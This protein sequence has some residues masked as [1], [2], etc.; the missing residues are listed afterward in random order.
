MRVGTFFRESKIVMRM[1]EIEWNYQ[2]NSVRVGMTWHGQGELVLM[3]PALSSISTRMEMWPLQERLGSFFTTLAMDWVGFGDRPRP[4]LRWS[5]EIYRS[6]LAYLLDEVVPWPFA[7]IA[8]GH[9]AAY[10]L[11][12]AAARPGSTGRLCLI[13]PTWRGPLPTMMGRKYPMFAQISRMVDWPVVGDLLYRLNVN[14]FMVR[15]M[16]LGHVY[17][18]SSSLSEARFEEKLAVTRAS[19]ARHSSIRFVAGELDPMATREAF[20]SAA[21]QV[22]DPIIVVYGA[23]TPPRSRAE[24][25]VLAG[26]PN[27]VAAVVP[28][29]KLAVH[30]EFPDEVAATIKK[31]LLGG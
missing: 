2:G 31:F 19:G 30:E 18:E 15:K 7:T 3:L 28:H 23:E 22:N 4:P 11:D 12:A 10:C 29:A 5:P 13:A 17:A 25:E 21:Q 6:F 27:V 14:R 1:D 20:L 24:M 16:A 8:A 9:A 26:L